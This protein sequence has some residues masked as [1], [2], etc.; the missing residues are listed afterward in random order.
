M[1]SSQSGRRFDLFDPSTP[2]RSFASTRTRTRAYS[3]G[4]QYRE[5][6]QAERSDGPTIRGFGRLNSRGAE[7]PHTTKTKSGP[8]NSTCAEPR[9]TENLLFVDAAG[10]ILPLRSTIGRLRGRT[11]ADGSPIQWKR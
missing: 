11:L 5:S 6:S 8:P 2:W 1:R 9:W 7:T 10:Q 3:P 4:N